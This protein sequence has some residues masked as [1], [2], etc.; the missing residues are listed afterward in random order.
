VTLEGAIVRLEPLAPQHTPALAAIGGA[1]ELWEFTM[2]RIAGYADAAAYVDAALLGAAQGTMLPFATVLQAEHRVIGSTRFANY[3]RDALR[4][5]IGW[6]WIAPAWQRTGAN[7]EAKLLMMTHAFEQLGCN[8]VEFKTD[9]LNQK[10][11]HALL[12]IGAR[13]EGVLREHCVL[14]H[15]RLRDTI[16]YSVLAR[17]WPQVKQQLEQRLLTHRAARSGPT[18]PAG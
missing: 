7:V 3:D 16:Y 4:L 15:G 17:E 10:S 18:I 8:R 14:W 13:E 9:V 2:T 5:E 11:R 6:T 1:P 12:G